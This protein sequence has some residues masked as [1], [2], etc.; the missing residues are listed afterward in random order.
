MSRTVRL[1]STGGLIAREKAPGGGL[2]GGAELLARMS[3]DAQVSVSDFARVG[4]VDLTLDDVRMLA[5]QIRD[6]LDA[7]HHGVVVTLGTDRMA[8]VAWALEL[9]LAD[10]DA[11]IVLTG[12]MRSIDAARSDAVGNFTDAVAVARDEQAWNRGVLVCM[13]GRL[14]AA[15]LVHKRHADQV[16]AFSSYPLGEVGVIREQRVSFERRSVRRPPVATD[17]DERVEVISVGLGLNGI[18][19]WLRRGDQQTRG[20]V[21]ET[22]GAFR[23]PEQHH[24]DVVEIMRRGIV[25]VLAT[26]AWTGNVGGAASVHPRA[27]AA[28]AMSVHMARLTLMAAMAMTDDLERIASWFQPPR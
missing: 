8:Q 10:V 16:D 7:G 6:G 15:R 13:H 2:I 11:P 19:D 4:S 23:L 5:G 25:V 28:P 22:T 27:I 14:H 20:V 17:F 3:A 9:L 18:A 24:D 26:P 1:I 12:A 21:I